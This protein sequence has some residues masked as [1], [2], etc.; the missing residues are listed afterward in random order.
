MVSVMRI[1][2]ILVRIRKV[3]IM[4]TDQQD[5]VLPTVRYLSTAG[6]FNFNKIPTVRLG[7]YL[8]SYQYVPCTYQ[9][10]PY[11]VPTYRMLK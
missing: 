4:K 2:A 11:T 6:N 10:V 9:P 8:L 5:L 7:R 3:G 1:R